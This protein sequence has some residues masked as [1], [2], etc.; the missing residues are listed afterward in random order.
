[1]AGSDR[2]GE[3]IAEYFKTIHQTIIWPAVS[4]KDGK[5]PG[6]RTDSLVWFCEALMRAHARTSDVLYVFRPVTAS[7]VGKPCTSNRQCE[8]DEECRDG[9]C[10]PVPP[11]PDSP[12]LFTALKP[13]TSN[14]QCEQDEECVEGWCTP[15][16]GG[17]D[18][19]GGFDPDLVRRPPVYN[20]TVSTALEEYY[21]RLHDHMLR[22]AAVKP[23]QL[24]RI[25]NILMELYCDCA[26]ASGAKL[27]ACNGNG[28][29]TDGSACVKG[30]CVPVPFRMVFRSSPFKAPWA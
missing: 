2:L 13:C 25:R 5:K 1:M 28:D 9:F 12:L 16:V 7:E 3:A 21:G 26:K 24:G 18:E 15:I 10:V 30:F 8:Q 27:T 11:P 20:T 17:G 14:R 22:A 19:G 6:P 23:K 29:C 4:S